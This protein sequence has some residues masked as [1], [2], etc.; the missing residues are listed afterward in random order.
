VAN[1]PLS[2]HISRGLVAAIARG[3]IAPDANIALLS[4]MLWD[5]GL[6]M[7]PHAVFD[8]WPAEQLAER[9]REKIRAILAGSR[10]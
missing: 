6:S 7:I 1:W 9:L 4:Q 3:Q 10:L 5:A 2:D 8:S